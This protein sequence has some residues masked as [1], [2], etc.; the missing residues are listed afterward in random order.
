MTRPVLCGL[1]AAAATLGPV[2][3]GERPPIGFEVGDAFPVDLSLVEA[4]TGKTMSLAAF[5]G[6]K[7]LLIVYASW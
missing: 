5:R 7:V 1:L 4:A 6:Q 2:I 3:A